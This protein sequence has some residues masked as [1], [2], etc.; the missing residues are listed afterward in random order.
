[1]RFLHLGYRDTSGLP[2]RWTQ[3]HRDAG[4]DARLF[5]ELSHPFSYPAESEIRRWTPGTR[6]AEHRAEVIADVL[7]WADAVVAYDHPFY[8]DAAIASDKPVLFRALGQS[9]R[10]YRDELA[11]LLRSWNVVR[12]TAGTPD[13]AHI[14]DI[15]LT[16]APF[17]LLEPAEPVEGV[18]CHAPSSREGK[19]T[20]MVLRA[21]E[22]TGWRVDLI[23]NAPNAEVLA[24]K[25]RAAL[26][27]DAIGPHSTPD[28]YGE[29]GVE[30]MAMGLPVVTWATPGARE[31]W[32]THGSPVWCVGSEEE[33]VEALERL[34][35]DG[36]LRRRLGEDGRRFVET[37]HSPSTRVAEDV[38]A[39]RLHILGNTV[40]D[41]PEYEVAVRA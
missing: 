29:N 23:E 39:V 10:E 41:L 25:S 16:G 37:F 31:A 27:V 5:V 12:A 38:E 7:E 1:M 15:S 3:A 34:R 24:R 21:A 17:P 14:L 6:S 2:G 19:G 30:G 8:L 9:T 28:G 40:G 4:L 22:A 35:E 36:D 32:L 11:E 33:L 18:L 20:E 13:L 26:V